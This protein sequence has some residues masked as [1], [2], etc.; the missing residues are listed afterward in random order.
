M[1]TA[2][3]IR[4]K[5]ILPIKMQT[6]K[7][8]QNA[9]TILCLFRGSAANLFFKRAE[10]SF[11]FIFFIFDVLFLKSRAETLKRKKTDEPIKR[12]VK[13]RVAAEIREKF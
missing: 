7:N 2:A 10:L 9:I 3:A 6:A 11:I 4:E 5:I 1:Y 13:I 12:E 8:M